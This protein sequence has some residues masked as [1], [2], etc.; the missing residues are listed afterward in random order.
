MTCRNVDPVCERQ[1]CISCCRR[2]DYFKFDSDARSW[3]CPVC[4]NLCNCA[5]CLRK[6]G[7]GDLVADISGHYFGRGEKSALLAGESVQEFVARSTKKAPPPFDRVRIV[8]QAEDIVS[9]PLSEE[10]KAYLQ[11]QN[12]PPNV[13]GRVRGRMGIRGGRGRGG[14]GRGHGRP[15]GKGKEKEV[16]EEPQ[17]VEG[18]TPTTDPT[19]SSGNGESSTSAHP[20]TLRIPGP[21]PR[22]KV[23]DSDGDTVDGYSTD[24]PIPPITGAHDDRDREWFDTQ[25]RM[26]RGTRSRSSTNPHTYVVNEGPATGTINDYLASLAAASSPASAF[27]PLPDDAI[28][29]DAEEEAESPQQPVLDVTLPPADMA[30]EEPA[31]LAVTPIR[32]PTRADTR[33]PLQTP[34]TSSPSL[35]NG[36]P[37]SLATV[38]APDFQASP[39]KAVFP[40]YAPEFDLAQGTSTRWAQRAVDPTDG[41]P[42]VVGSVPITAAVAVNLPAPALDDGLPPV[43]QA[44]P[45]EVQAEGQHSNSADQ[46]PVAGAEP[47][48]E[49]EDVAMADATEEDPIPADDTVL[50]MAAVVD[51]VQPEDS[52]SLRPVVEALVQAVAPGSIIVD[53][54]PADAA[55]QVTE[56]LEAA[57]ESMVVD[58]PPEVHEPLTEEREDE[59]PSNLEEEPASDEAPA[60]EV[61]ADEPPTEEADQPSTEDAD[62]P[63]TAD[64]EAG[65]DHPAPDDSP[66]DEPTPDVPTTPDAVDE[67]PPPAREYSPFSDLTS[68]P[69]SEAPNLA[70][71][72]EPASLDPTASEASQSAPANTNGHHK[73]GHRLRRSGK[74]PAAAPVGPTPVAEPAPAEPTPPPSPIRKRRPPPP[75]AH[76]VRAP[77]YQRANLAP[78]APAERVKTPTPTKEETRA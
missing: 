29:E 42:P 14:R 19:A 10:W 11:R 22:E 69:D 33:F 1:F 26:R 44:V 3:Q 56:D 64:P 67:A 71:V 34:P 15:K 55:A 43:V 18:S 23:V 12:A 7:L 5:A 28:E 48:T 66:V 51:Q 40:P 9:P 65:H 6:R 72:A 41:L 61:E 52:D 35:A 46:L 60:P 45:L 17:L 75:A 36:V 73:G 25:M 68:L 31:H 47:N 37:P 76:I 13:R 74:A 39:L 70:D 49:G 58:E 78:A 50:T 77:K 53:Q 30:T 21:A 38:L 8:V 63:P 2:Y 62:E 27:T 54:L 16:D 24:S 59:G 32:T 4:L 20:I 57:D